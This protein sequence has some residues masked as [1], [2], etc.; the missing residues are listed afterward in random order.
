MSQLNVEQ[1]LKDA[2]AGIGQYLQGALDA[3][4]IN[5]GL[6]EAASR[7]T[8]PN[9]REWLESRRI[10]EVS[11]NLKAGIADAVAAGRWEELVNAYRQYM[12]FGTG[13]IR[14]MM[15]FDKTSIVKMQQDGLD[16]RILKGPNT[17]NNIIVTRV[18]AGVAKFGKDGG[19]NFDRIVI[20]YDSRVRGG[21]FARL[22]AELFLAYGYTVYLFDEPCP[23][24]EV[25]FAIPYKEIK[26]HVG[27]LISASHNDYRYNGYKLSSGNG[28]QFDPKERDEMY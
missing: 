28:S 3:G 16:A 11:P 12:R 1:I 26:A 8:L 2:E 10:D 4:K 20:G 22:I 18:S 5:R 27:L 14:G 19:R 13:G 21:D 7:E 25:T 9:L 15:A 24:P 17:L 6:Y 23:Y